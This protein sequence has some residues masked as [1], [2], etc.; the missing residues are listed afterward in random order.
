MC[1]RYALSDQLAAEREFLPATAWWKF[2]ARFNVSAGQYVPAIRLH[3][4]QS[5]GVMLRWGLIPSWVEGRLAGPPKVCVQSS[6]I[7]RSNSYRMPWLNS[8]RCILPAAGFYS[9]RLTTEKYRQPFFVRLP[10]R[11]VFGFAAIWDRW[12]G[13][14]DDVIESC[15]VVCVPA[16][17]LMSEIAGPAPGMPAI[18]RRK[19]YDTWLHG[20]PVEAKAALQPYKAEWMQAYP[21]SP[22][23][24]SVAV[25]D[26]DLI[27]AAG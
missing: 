6:C 15:S 26:A 9:W 14:D 21:V 3:D 13:D 19:D 20:N 12:V 4:G 25:D 16:N 7:E 2:A 24:N 18:L 27:R 23:I 1:R 11:A 8:Q 10:D 5:E 22:R 17:E